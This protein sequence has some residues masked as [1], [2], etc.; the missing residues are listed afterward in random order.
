METSLFCPCMTHQ[1]CQYTLNWFVFNCCDR[2][3]ISIWFIV[4]VRR[5]WCGIGNWQNWILAFDLVC[6]LWLCRNNFE[7]NGPICFVSINDRRF[8][9]I[10][11]IQSVADL[12]FLIADYSIRNR[13]RLKCIKLEICN[14]I[15]KNWQSNEKCAYGSAHRTIFF[16]AFHLFI[17]TIHIVS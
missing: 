5:N 6:L 10:S 14:E 1:N 2:I 13:G 9:S 3:L 12:A 4:F 17:E 15:G 16:E 11:F 8:A 7:W